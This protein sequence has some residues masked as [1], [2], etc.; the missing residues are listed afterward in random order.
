M[1]RTPRTDKMAKLNSQ[2][3]AGDGN[4]LRKA[5]APPELI[6]YGSIAKLTHGT[7]TRRS[8]GGNFRRRSGRC[9]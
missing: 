3:A 8:D 9:L 2:S 7:R 1:S 6:E 5:Y 4:S